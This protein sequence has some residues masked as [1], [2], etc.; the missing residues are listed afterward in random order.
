VVTGGGRQYIL[1][2][3]TQHSQGDEYLAAIAQAVDN[4]MHDASLQA[5]PGGHR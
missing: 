3:L 1:V 4:L 2:A 5:S